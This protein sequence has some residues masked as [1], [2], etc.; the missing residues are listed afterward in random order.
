MGYCGITKKLSDTVRAMAGS[1][2]SEPSM[3]GQRRLLYR[4]V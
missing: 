3:D 2:A 4:T 1:G